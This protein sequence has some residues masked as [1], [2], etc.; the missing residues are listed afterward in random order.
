MGQWSDA[1]AVSTPCV[2]GSPEAPV[3]VRS[4]GVWPAPLSHWDPAIV[5]NHEE[6]SRDAGAR[7]SSS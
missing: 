4:D 2:W 5:R 7:G 1:A 6:A 3:I